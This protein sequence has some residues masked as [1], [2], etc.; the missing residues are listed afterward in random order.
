MTTTDAPTTFD[1][2]HQ[3]RDEPVNA[4]DLDAVRDARAA[5]GVTG[6]TALDALGA[7]IEER[8]A[9]E[10]T[11]VDVEVPGLDIRLVCSTVVPYEE[12]QKWQITA[13]PPKE[14]KKRKINGLTMSQMVLACMVLVNTCDAI[15]HKVGGEWKPML[16]TDG[17]VYTLRSDELLRR[18]N[19]I[20]VNAF[21]KKLFGRDPRVLAA[22]EKVIVA[23][24]WLEDEDDLDP[25]A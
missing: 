9:E 24:E 12:Y 11:T 13:L 6:L 3:P 22:S 16:G 2:S 15:E 19:V 4:P 25:T 10:E 23:S 1:G 14:R 7:Q 20:D 17:E 18:F 21:I 5:H 8:D